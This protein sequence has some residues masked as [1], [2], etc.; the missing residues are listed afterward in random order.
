MT[1]V[2]GTKGRMRLHAPAHCPERLTLEVATGRGAAD[3]IE[4]HFPIPE[5]KGWPAPGWHYPNQHGFVYQARAVHRCVGAGWR[6][7]PQYPHT[8]IVRT[9]R[10]MDE[11]KSKHTQVSPLFS[12]RVCVCV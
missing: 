12:P 1:D 4:M 3:A 10:I 2:I 5:P 8:E 7:C 6:E 9:M 11:A